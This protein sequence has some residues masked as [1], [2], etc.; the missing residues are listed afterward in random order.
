MPDPAGFQAPPRMTEATTARQ[1]EATFRKFAGEAARTSDQKIQELAP[2]WPAIAQLPDSDARFDAIHFR[3]TGGREG[4]VPPEAMPAMQAVGKVFDDYRAEVQRRSSSRA[5]YNNFIENYYQHQYKP[6]SGGVP[7]AD[8]IARMGNGSF[9]RQRKIP[10][11][12]EARAAGLEPV[13]DDPI[14]QTMMYVRNA[15]RF[16]AHEDIMAEAKS[17]GLIKPV[18]AGTKPP[19]GW[20]PVR[21]RGMWTDYAPEGWARVHKNAVSKGLTGAAGD[22][23]EP[24][25]KT[26]NAIT[27]WELALSGYHAVTMTGEAMVSEVARAVQQI[28]HGKIDGLSTLVK[29]PGAPYGLFKRGKEA[30]QA[31]LGSTAGSQ[32]MRRVIDLLEKAGGRG[33]SYTQA[34]DYQVTG[35]GSYWEAAKHGALKMQLAA[36]RQEA[37]GGPLAAGKVL[38]KNVGRTLDTITAPLFEKYIPR[39]KNGAFY[40]T[41]STW[42]DH[43]PGASEAAQVRAARMIW[44]SIDNRFGEVIHDNIFW[45]KTLKQ[46]AMLMQRS[47]SW[48]LGTFREIGG[49]AKDIVS[50]DFK[51]PRA[52]YIVALPL[53]TAFTSAIYQA[54]KTGQAPAD[55][56]D[57][58]SPRTGGVDPATGLPERVAPIGYFK[59]VMSWQEDPLRTAAS[60]IATGPRIAG[61]LATGHDWRGDPIRSP[62]SAWGGKEWASEYGRHIGEAFLPISVRNE[63]QRK[64]GSAISTPERIMG[65]SP[66]GRG[67]VDPEGI[68]RMKE[69]TAKREWD[70]KVRYQR[71][72][73]SYYD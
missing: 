72:Q 5:G 15:S 58:I 4:H 11:I 20:A 36:D 37:R 69:R 66:G 12:K 61:E 30:E 42:L 28:A 22:M 64:H 73:E 53:V 23:Y 65:V 18:Q 43:N 51:S 44:D 29:A 6:S 38:A 7:N 57:L 47:Y 19:E 50:G 48:N 55:I 31:W 56:H 13:T 52:A 40:E 27:A 33:K 14:Q 63:W 34:T 60:K 25:Q 45:N 39:L 41:M 1:A 59:D 26:F 35:A 67:Y 68:A 9:L 8:T 3:E 21:Q 62:D 24:V 32:K 2:H 10:T 16:M 71:R 17:Q 54:L 49:G 70:R 46:A